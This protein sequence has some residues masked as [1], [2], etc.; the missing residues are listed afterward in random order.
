ML[1]KDIRENIKKEILFLIDFRGHEYV[2]GEYM[3][4]DST[5]VVYCKTHKETKPTTFYNYKRA[6]HGLPCCGFQTRSD[7]KEKRRA[8]AIQRIKLGE[9]S[10]SPNRRRTYEARLWGNLVFKDWSSKCAITQFTVEQAKIITHHFFSGT[11][12]GNA[13]LHKKLMYNNVNGITLLEI[14]HKDFHSQYGYERNTL[15]QFQTYVADL[16]KLIRS[17]APQQCGSGSETRVY[18]PGIKIT[19][20]QSEMVVRGWVTKDGITKLHERL[21]EI[22]CILAAQISPELLDLL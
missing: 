22:K 18:D 11:K 1:C 8:E 15:S 17:Q 21:E 20:L 6:K 14:I 16:D 10:P 7:Y 5:L 12:T 3:T 9:F 13:V 2:S 19:H 4:K